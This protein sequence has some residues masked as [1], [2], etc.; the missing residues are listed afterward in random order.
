MINRVYLFLI[1]LLFS[2]F[3]VSCQDVLTNGDFELFSPTPTDYGQ[4]SKCQGWQSTM[5]NPL[6]GN[7]ASPD[8]YYSGSFMG[9]FYGV[10]PP[11][12][13][14]GQV[15]LF[16]WIKDQPNYRDYVTR[17]LDAPLTPGQTYQVGF[18]INS[19]NRGGIINGY[20]NNLGVCFT[21]N[22][23][24]NQQIAE[25]LSSLIPQW[26]S[27]S[28]INTSQNWVFTTFTF[29]PS[30]AVNHVTIG[31]FRD[32]AATLTS[33][34]TSPS[35]RGAYYFIDS[36]YVKL[37]NPLL[38]ING[39]D[40]ICAGQSTTLTAINGESYSWAVS[41]APGTILS[42]TAQLTVNPSATTTYLVY[43]P[44]DTA[45][46]TV[47]VFP[48]PVVNL[49]NVISVCEGATLELNA[50]NPGSTYVWQDGSTGQTFT[51]QQQGN[52]SVVVARNGCLGRD[53]I[54][55]NYTVIPAFSLGNDTTLCEGETLSL[56]VALQQVD[57]LWQDN[58]TASSILI[59]QPGNYRVKVSRNGCSKSD[60]IAVSFSDR[61]FVN[62]GNDTTICE[63]EALT[64]ESL[65]PG[66]TYS[67]QDGSVSTQ[68]S[69]TQTGNYQLNINNNGCTGS[70]EIF[71]TVTPLPVFSLGNDTVLC[72]GSTLVLNAAVQNGSFLWQ[73]NSV[74]ATF[75]VTA[76][77]EY[78]VQV[79]VGNCTVSK[80]VTVDVLAVPDFTLGNDTTICKGDTL[81]LDAS[82]TEG[83]Y[84]WQDGSAFSTFLV[85]Q[86]GNY[87]LSIS[88]A[89]CPVSD[90][91][92]ITFTSCP[93][94]IEFP[95]VFS[96]NGDLY[97]EQF[98][99]LVKTGI[100][101]VSI[102]IFNRWGKGV[103]EGSSL[104]SG[105]DGTING[106]SCTEGVYFW[107][108]NYEDVNGVSGEKKGSLTLLR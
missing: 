21:D 102:S 1:S 77:G 60:S 2:P 45:S 103:Y 6:D 15:G 52:Y 95:T 33:N 25:H 5:P 88:N 29:N 35:H 87:A 24:P 12:S 44:N 11:H 83:N 106:N 71:V 18:Y 81:L 58:T 86:S 96:P 84:T 9:S 4:V 8:Y 14:N 97:N 38:T 94:N 85:L 47:N 56:N 7:Y 62:L 10:R 105:W 53:S 66:A 26:E 65:F 74:E 70:D 3:T 90:T 89:E 28:I 61:P 73:D 75:T 39:D 36:V 41:S 91:I 42:T 31:N 59:T 108:V 78:S 104:I 100:K 20:S 63:G 49:G 17:Q 32:D 76:Q 19:G 43:S 98:L 22:P 34:A 101:Q 27:S 37:I 93:S 54:Q 50:A 80:A 16:T 30:T 67:W 69:V 51:V 68:F 13:G 99:P 107:I 57:F 40:S 55:V 64:L 92:G 72:E 48:V 23:P 79:T 82:D 46:F